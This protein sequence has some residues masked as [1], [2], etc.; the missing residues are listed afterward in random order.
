MKAIPAA[1]KPPTIHE[2]IIGKPNPPRNPVL[3]GSTASIFSI[4]GPEIYL[5]IT[6]PIIIIAAII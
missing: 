6:K 4:A 1:N 5:M 2:K 3:A